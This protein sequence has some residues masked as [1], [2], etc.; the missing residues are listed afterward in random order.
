MMFRCVTWSVMLAVSLCLLAAD[1]HNWRR[2]YRT[3]VTSNRRAAAL[4]KPGDWPAPAAAP[5][6]IDPARFARALRK[7]CGFMPKGRQ[8]RYA[9]WMIDYA[10]RFGEDP[11]VLAALTYRLSRC[12]PKANKVQGIGLTAIQSRMYRGNVRGR[13]LRYGFEDGTHWVQ[14]EHALDFGFFEKSIQRAQ[15]NLHW[16]AALLAMWREQHETADA[17]FEG[18]PHNHHVSHFVWGDRVR[19]ARAEDRVMTD[20]RRLLTYYGT[21]PPEPHKAWR[22]HD[23]ISPLDGAPRVVTGVPGDSRDGG[24]R[25]HRGVDVEGAFGEPV[26]AMTDGVVVFAGVDLPGGGNNQQCKKD[27]YENF[28]RRELG[29]GG[30]FVCIGHGETAEGE[31]WLR[32]CYMH[33]ETVEVVAGQRVAAGEH[34]GTLGRTGMKSSAPHLHLEIK[35]NTRLY[36][37]REVLAGVL[38]G[39][40]PKE[41]KRRRRRRR[42]KTLAQASAPVAAN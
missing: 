28:P 20:R 41:P 14:R 9:G 38:I 8:H 40:P 4:V 39:T 26:R 36:N 5:D 2:R 11:F 23:W 31:A 19:S 34:I 10:T 32:S 24:E 22:G 18:V 27:E 13:K 3:G 12:D 17:R 35:S 33:L 25:K 37:A 7:L 30:R 16:A 42:Q 29:R 1:G 6:T 21:P 15:A